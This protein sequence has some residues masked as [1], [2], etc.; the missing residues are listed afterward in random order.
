M[1]IMKGTFLF[2]QGRN[3][4]SESYYIEATD[5]AAAQTRFKRLATNRSLLLGKGSYIDGIRISDEA[6]LND[7]YPVDLGTGTATQDAVTDTPWNSIYVRAQA[8]ALYRRQ[9]HLRGV[10]D[11]WITIDPTTGKGIIP[12][13]ARAAFDAWAADATGFAPVM[14]LKVMSKT[15]DAVAITGQPT[16]DGTFTKFNVGAVPGLEAVPYVLLRKWKGPDRKTLNRRWDVI[17]Y[18]NP[19]VTLALPWAYL[20]DP[21][22][23]YKGMLLR[24][25]PAYADMTDLFLTRF[26]SKKTGRAFFV[27]AGKAPAKKD[28]TTGEPPPFRITSGRP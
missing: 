11:S 2:G 3:G 23:D 13:V 4:W 9:F 6:I 1:P 14:K 27:S 8:G 28:P 7:S 16:Q 10:P 25:V 26:A 22:H 18:A 24:R 19:W 20:R 5:Y 12:A 17:T 15:L 21:D